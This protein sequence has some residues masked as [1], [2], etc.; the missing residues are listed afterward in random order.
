MIDGSEAEELEA[1][2]TAS[3]AEISAMLDRDPTV[4]AEFEI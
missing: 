1:S 3:P 2:E 4:L